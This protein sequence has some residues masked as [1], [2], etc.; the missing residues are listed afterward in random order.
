MNK[1]I[2]AAG[3]IG[4]FFGLLLGLVIGYFIA[5]PSLSGAGI[6]NQVRVSGTVHQ[7]EAYRIVFSSVSNSS[8]KTTGLIA[9][10][11]SYGVLVVGGQSYSVQVLTYQAG[12][13][14]Y[15]F[16]TYVP[17]GVS[18]FTADF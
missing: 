18:K 1:V 17:L 8:I 11:G 2:F 4:L 9:N 14:D 16:T 3:F 13:P 7:T 10:D 12:N 5:A 15:S 6:D